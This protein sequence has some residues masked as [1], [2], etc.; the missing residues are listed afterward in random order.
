MDQ[1][2]THRELED[3]ITEQAGGNLVETLRQ[4]LRGCPHCQ[5]KLD[6]MSDDLE[7]R[8]WHRAPGSHDDEDEPRQP[9]PVAIS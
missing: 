6:E 2:P 3:L 8:G 7:L 1:C 9:S 4:H 5:A